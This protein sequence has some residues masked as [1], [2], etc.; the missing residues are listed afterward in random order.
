ME[1]ITSI[2]MYVADRNAE[3]LGVPRLVLMEN[4]GA[5]VA[6]NVLRKFPTAK[7]ILVVC[8]TGDNGG[9]GYVAARHL[10]AAGRAV[11]VIALGE[12][13]E[14]LARINYQAVTRLWGVEVKAVQST[15]ELLAL[16]D[17]FMWAEVIVDAVLGT[18]IRGVL[19]EPHATAIE[20]MNIAPAPKVAVDVP[21]GLD[22]DTGEVRDKAVRAA[23][24]VTFHKAKRGLLSPGAQR[25]VGEL[26]VE[27]IGIP[28]EAELVVGPGDFAYLNFTRRADSKKGDHGRVLVIGGSLE[29]SGAPVY[30]ALAALRAGVDLAV[31]AA[32]EPAAYAAKAISPDIIAIPL[33]GPRLSTKHVDKL[34]SLAE[35]FNVVAM[36]PGLGVE[37]ETQEAVRELFRRLAGKRAMVIDADALKALRGVRAS[38]AVV[39]T[40]HAGEFKSLTGAEPPQSLSERMAVVREQAAALGGVILL[41]GRYDVISDGVRVKVN[42]TGTPAMTVG[43]TGDVLTGLVAAF[44]TKTSDPLEAA[45]VAAFVNGLAGEDAAAELGFHITASDLIERL[46]RVIRRYAFESIR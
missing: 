33:E 30:V 31:I 1:S 35:R 29:Y 46:P 4:A 2:E 32:P 44:L 38:G 28:P 40:P 5:A 43:G 8:G 14:E 15:L 20:L 45:A 22:P 18:G 11:R 27:P 34:A 25:Y 36:G 6:R 42:M 37:E 41:K 7:R 24:T 39:Y 23:L 12:P 19:R 9:D 21:S 10:H 3:W 13:R 26:V 17:W 16:Q